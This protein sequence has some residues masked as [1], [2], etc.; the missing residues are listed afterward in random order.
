MGSF[1]VVLG[2]G[3]VDWIARLA[4]TAV[5]EDASCPYDDERDIHS[6]SLAKTV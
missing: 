2:L 4:G 5:L 3:L 1:R 6:R